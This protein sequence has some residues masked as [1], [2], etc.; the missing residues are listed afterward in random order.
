MSR[1][2]GGRPRPPGGGANAGKFQLDR[3]AG[4]PRLLFLTSSWQRE[5]EPP[6]PADAR[7]RSSTQGG[8]LIVRDARREQPHRASRVVVQGQMRDPD[9]VLRRSR[10][11]PEI[12]FCAEHDSSAVRKPHR[13]VA[14]ERAHPL[15]R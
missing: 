5:T 10:K 1:L 15:F 13:I 2:L 6:R 14:A 7:M 9:L 3:L 12:S 4:P 11:R 8:L